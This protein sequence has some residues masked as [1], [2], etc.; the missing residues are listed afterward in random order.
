MDEYEAEHTHPMNRL[1][2]MFGIPT[3]ALSIVLLPFSRKLSAGLF[4]A[5][6]SMQL[7]GHAIEGNR[8]GFLNR[9]KLLSA[10]PLWAARQWR[11]L[12]EREPAHGPNLPPARAAENRLS[13]FLPSA[14][15]RVGDRGAL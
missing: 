1:A 15:E 3:V 9:P 13:P 2:H 5:G 11:N 6:W 10:G 7:I 8:P 4:V 12:F 14:G